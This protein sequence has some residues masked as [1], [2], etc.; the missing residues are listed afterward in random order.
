MPIPRLTLVAAACAL[1]A[2]MSGPATTSPNHVRFE[3]SFPASVRTQ[4]V[5]GRMY[6][7]ISADSAPEPRL[8]GDDFIASTPLFGVDVTGLAPGQ[9][10]E[11]DDTTRSYPVASLSA[12][13][14]GDYWVQ[15]VLS[16]YT[17][18]HRADGH[19]IWAHMDQWEGQHF[20][21]SPGNLVSAMQRVHI[22]P[23]AGYAIPVSLTRVLP[24]IELPPDSKWVKHVKIQSDL[25]TKFWGHPIYLGATLLLPA[26]YDSHPTGDLPA[27]TLRAPPAP[28]RFRHP[29]GSR[30]RTVRGHA[31]RLQPAAGDGAL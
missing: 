2:C 9:T 14:A 3:I 16:V 19:V 23:A 7:M 18:F 8:S 21:T 27:G 20:G 11:I 29:D 28:A 4:P 5:T 22:D 13:P 25:L 12:I 30:A 26:G 1:S 10:A 6:L 15:A 24:P 31:R 17:E